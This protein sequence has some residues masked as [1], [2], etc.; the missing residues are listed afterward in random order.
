MRQ[1]N[2]STW[3]LL[4]ICLIATLVGLFQ[5]GQ[6]VAFAIYSDSFTVISIEIWQVGLISLGVWGVF[7]FVRTMKKLNSSPT[8]A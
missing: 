1:S 6:L 2:F 4:T 5:I 7:E 3:F 8:D